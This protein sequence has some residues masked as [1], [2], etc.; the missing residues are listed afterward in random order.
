MKRRDFLRVAA[1]ATAAAALP[2]GQRFA[3]A[4]GADCPRY[5]FIV[6]GNG[7]EPAS[8]LTDTAR[9]AIDE[10]MGSPIGGDR[11]WYN[12]MRHDSPLEVATPDFETAHALGPLRDEGLV[13]QATVLLG[14]SSR[15][16]GGGHSGYHGSLASARTIGGQPGG[17]TIDAHLAALDSVRQDTPFEAFRV[18][19]GGGRPID[20]GTC[21]YAARDTAPLILDAGAAYEFAYGAFAEG[22][23]GRAFDRR[24][25]MLR[26]AAEDLAA[27]ERRFTGDMSER[28]KLGSYGRSIES[29]LET[30]EILRGM[31]SSVVAPPAI[32]GGLAPLARFHALVDLAVSTLI[33]DLTHVAVV[34][35]G[36]GGSFSLTYSSI[37]GTGRHDMQHTSGGDPAML[38]AIRD[39]NRAQVAAIAAGARRLAD[40]GLLDRTVIV[41]V[42]DNGEQHHSTASEFPILLLGGSGVGLRSGGRTVVYPGVNSSENRQLSNLWNTMGYLAGES[43]DTFGGEEG[44]LR[45]A[46]GPLAELM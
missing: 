18:G 34:G 5:L 20:F 36:T 38:Q 39:V 23:A 27:A 35:S 13:D 12:R 37:S 9:A 46:A 16:V 29:L 21:A 10:T 45:K 24:E 6:E 28:A 11:W 17:P 25:R 3:H 22:A 32:A 42:G 8:V 43:L 2:L 1:G 19:V 40:A 14:L 4:D 33:D 7:F 44:D 41:W 15:I 30:Q 31:R 26:L